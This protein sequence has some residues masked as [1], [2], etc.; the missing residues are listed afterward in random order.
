MPRSIQS[1][2]AEC[3]VPKGYELLFT[4][5]K[6]VYYIRIYMVR[7]GLLAH[8]ELKPRTNHGLKSG[9]WMDVVSGIWLGTYLDKLNHTGGSLLAVI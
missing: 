6:V 3:D 9:V 5:A 4:M 7:C 8:W 1:L 2:R